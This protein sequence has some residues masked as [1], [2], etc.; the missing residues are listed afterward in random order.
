MTLIYIKLNLY[1]NLLYEIGQI[2]WDIQYENSEFKASCFWD[3]AKKHAHIQELIVNGKYYQ[4]ST[5]HK[6]LGLNM[7]KVPSAVMPVE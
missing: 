4:V 2:L 5:N 1:S 3:T 6:K 7:V